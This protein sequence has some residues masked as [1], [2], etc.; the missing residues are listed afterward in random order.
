MAAALGV[1]TAHYAPY[2]VFNMVSPIL[3]IVFAALN[4]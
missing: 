4:F 2:A 3:V 1:A